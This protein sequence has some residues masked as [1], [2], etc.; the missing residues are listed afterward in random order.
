MVQF[1]QLA[2]VQMTH[3]PYRGAAPAVTDLASGQVQ[4]LSVGAAP[5]AGLM[6]SGQVRALAAATK[7]RMPLMPDIPTASEAGVPGFEST[8]W[9]GVVAPANTPQPIVDKLNELLREWVADPKVKQRFDN[10]YLLPLNM[11]S[12]DFASFVQD[13]ANK[14]E[15]IVT[16]AAVKID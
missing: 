7:E 11:S 12:R 3:V 1:M 2:G 16:D 9:F 4:V 8:T 10:A 15:K 5:V 6:A 14:W 13:E